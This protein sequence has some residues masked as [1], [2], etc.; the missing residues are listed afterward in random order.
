MFRIE[1][2]SQPNTHETM[3]QS[4]KNSRWKRRN[5][6]FVVCHSN[7]IAHTHTI[8]IYS[9]SDAKFPLPF[10]YIFP[11]HFIL[12]THSAAFHCS[13]YPFRSFPFFFRRRQRQ[14]VYTPCTHKQKLDGFFSLARSFARFWHP[15]IGRL[16]YAY[17]FFT[18]R[19]SRFSSFVEVINFRA[20]PKSINNSFCYQNEIPNYNAHTIT[21]AD[22]TTFRRRTLLKNTLRT[23]K[24]RHIL[25]RNKARARM[26]EAIQS[27]KRKQTTLTSILHI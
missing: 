21:P 8:N 15:F 7:N 23:K 3:T 9:I 2:A 13:K 20:H 18:S 16:P 17:P 10:P 26:R 19:S 27:E 11:F 1:P 12:Y 5:H 24:K 4:Q 25:R 14:N 22:R 6:P